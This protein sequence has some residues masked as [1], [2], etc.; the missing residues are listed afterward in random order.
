MSGGLESASNM[1]RAQIRAVN[2]E[3]RS[4]TFRFESRQPAQTPTSDELNSEEQAVT[5]EQG[6]NRMHP[7]KVVEA[8]N[9]LLFTVAHE[10]REYRAVQLVDRQGGM[11]YAHTEIQVDDLVLVVEV[12][13]LL[14]GPNMSDS[15]ASDAVSHI[16][17]GLMPPSGWHEIREYSGLVKRAND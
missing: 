11:V 8:H 3:S 1:D 10:G 12:P 13:G 9:R 14:Y 2:S 4:Q 7:M 6:G 16:I 15:D 17:V 5:C